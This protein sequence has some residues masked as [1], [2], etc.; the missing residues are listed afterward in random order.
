MGEERDWPTKDIDSRKCS[1]EFKLR[2][3][4]QGKALRVLTTRMHHCQSRSWALPMAAAVLV[5]ALRAWAQQ[6]VPIGT[7]AQL[8]ERLND[9][10]T[11]PQ[12]AAALW[13]AKVASLDTGIVLFEHN[14]EKLF[15]PASNTKLYTVAMA[16][17]RLGPDYRIKTSMYSKARPG[18]SGTLKGDLVVY[19][20][21]DPTI[22]SHSQNGDADSAFA[23]LVAALS[24]AG[25]RKIKGDLIGDES[26]F[27]GPE[28]G[29][30]W[31]CDDL[32][33]NYGAEI[34]ALTINDNT[35]Q[36]TVRPGDR[37]GAQCRLTVSPL[38]S[39]VTFSNRTQTIEA[40][41]K[42]NI[43]F[44]RPLG[45]NLIYVTGQMG[46]DDTEYNEPLPFHNPA[47]LF[48]A[49]FK[50]ALAHQ[51]IKVTGKLRTVNWLERQLHPFES[52]QM[53]E[54]GTIDSPPL[55]AIA[56]LVEKPSQNLYADLL[57]AH[58]GEMGRDSSSGMEVSSEE[59]GIR[60]LDKFL[61][62]A[63]I[64]KG[65]VIFEEGSGLSRD[66]LATPSATVA[67]LQYMSRQTCAE[68]YR[69]SLPVAA[70]DGTL[71]N[72]MKGTP[73]A[74]NVRAKTG[75]LRWAKSLSGYVATA[76]NERLA[77]SFMVNRFQ[78]PAY[79]ANTDLDAMAV[80][81]AGFTGRSGNW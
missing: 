43:H 31:A 2:F 33:Y 48:V 60:E 49:L 14:A 42:R 45:E 20:R 8:R 46:L 63:G 10:I 76:A 17:E 30:G 27:R 35:L 23:P 24:K 62:R 15:S 67:V 58:V 75:S 36:M 41:G 66:N 19:G 16:L 28:F 12:Y 6:E 68:T 53:V 21:G 5:S 47:G 40:G 44:Y 65:G 51:G 74:G 57:L 32:E 29:S 81:L 9:R 13:G 11:Q 38:T 1:I 34:S 77:F 71:R 55:S 72:R 73:A 26:F 7:V 54:L 78:N 70:V 39:Y 79:S 64:S 61:S 22:N 50:E 3:T 37:L 4:C 59:L 69:G 18:R 52:A 25:V 56:G 80:L